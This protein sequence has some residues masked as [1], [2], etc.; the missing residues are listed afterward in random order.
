ML[1][2]LHAIRVMDAIM[3]VDAIVDAEMHAITLARVDAR[4]AVG[5][6]VLDS[7]VLTLLGNCSWDADIAVGVAVWMFI[8][9]L[10]F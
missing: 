4:W 8:L 5:Y 7:H 3:L 2:T 6:Y 1:A 10:R 9:Q